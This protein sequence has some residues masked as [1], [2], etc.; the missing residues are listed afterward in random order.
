M[1]VMN[2]SRAD[3]NCCAD[4]GRNC[5][6]NPGGVRR[7]NANAHKTTRL[8]EQ[9]PFCRVCC[10]QSLGELELLSVGGLFGTGLE[11]D[12]AKYPQ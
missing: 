1:D 2:K 4:L 8:P 7:H 6:L 3:A 9:Q 12:L 5:S 11:P 10:Q